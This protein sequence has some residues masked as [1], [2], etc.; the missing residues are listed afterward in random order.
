MHKSD[1][2]K[3][4]K[5][6]IFAYIKRL[7]MT[8]YYLLSDFYVLYYGIY[9]LTA[10]VGMVFTPFFFFYHLFDALVRYPVLLN[11]VKAVWN[12]RKSIMFTYFL[13]IVLMYVFTLFGYYWLKDS[14]PSN[15]CESTW[16]CLIT[17]IDRSFKVDGGIGGF[18]TP[19][20]EAKPGDVTYFLI[21]FFFD[22]IYFILLMIIMI[23]IVSG[24]FFIII[25][26]YLQTQFFYFFHCSSKINRFF[27]KIIYI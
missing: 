9:I 5:L 11:V 12:P 23:N 25:F 2:Q 16:T 1:N 6:N 22:N 21:R 15:F 3:N 13:F 17:A 4:D 10:I 8:V 26:C 24:I 19:S 7:L 14:Y 18:L 27:F 20:Y